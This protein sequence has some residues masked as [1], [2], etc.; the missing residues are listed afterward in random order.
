MT[1]VANIDLSFGD[2][3][4]SLYSFLFS[5]SA[6]ETFLPRVLAAVGFAGLD[7]SADFVGF[8]VFPTGGFGTAAVFGNRR[9]LSI[10]AVAGVQVDVELTAA[11]IESAVA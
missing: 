6:N 1:S 8:L 3:C 10:V 5:F 4:F 7:D 11:R 9:S 2:N